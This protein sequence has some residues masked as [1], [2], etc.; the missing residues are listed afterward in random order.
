MLFL[1]PEMEKEDSI[2]R[3]ERIGRV[4]EWIKIACLLIIAIVALGVGLIYLEF[5]LVPLVLARFCVYLFQPFINFMV[6]K[7]ALLPRVPWCRI[8]L[9][10]PL[11]VL[12][13]F[14][15]TFIFIAL[16]AIIIFF[17]GKLF[18]LV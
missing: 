5:L 1:V 9:P 17:S 3:E 13:S 7:K 6:G 15:I 2:L 18:F 4:S 11:A 16:L 8:H 14:I 10:R 12:V